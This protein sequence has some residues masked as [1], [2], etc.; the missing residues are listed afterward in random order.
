V[1]FL[2]FIPL[3]VS[4][5]NADLLSGLGGVFSSVQTTPVANTSA[6]SAVLLTT[7]H[8]LNPLED[9]FASPG[10]LCLL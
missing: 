2:L 7:N 6:H 4:Q 3:D 1:I 5:S 9:T 10:E 8:N